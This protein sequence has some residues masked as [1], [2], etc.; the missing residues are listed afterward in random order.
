MDEEKPKVGDESEPINIT[1]VNQ[2][3]EETVFK[4]KKT[5]KMDKVFKAFAQR[6]G[7]SQNSLRFKVD[8][9]GI[10]ADQTPK[11]LELE[12]GDMIEAY[13]EQVG[14]GI[15]EGSGDDADEKADEALTLKIADQGGGDMFFKVK[16]NTPMRKIFEAYA[17]RKGLQTNVLRFM[18]DGH[19]IKADDT[20]KLLDIMDNDQID[21]QLEQI[22]GW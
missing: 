2:S 4:V 21:V 18:Y 11:E 12:D 16:K 9:E 10:R 6:V 15:D 17:A 20:P 22:G 14:G 13:I 19:R 5:T 1:V 7:V 3:G 8:G